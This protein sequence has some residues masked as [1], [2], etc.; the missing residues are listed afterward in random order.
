MLSTTTSLGVQTCLLLSSKRPGLPG[1]SMQSAGRHA[2]ELAHV[3]GGVEERGAVAEDAQ[4]G[5]RQERAEQRQPQGEVGAPGGH[6]RVRRACS[7]AFWGVPSV[8]WT[9]EGCAFDK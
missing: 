2:D 3:Q 8:F 5:L 1:E 6:G 7:T 4:R 9:F